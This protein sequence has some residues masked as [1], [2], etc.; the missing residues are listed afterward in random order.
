MKIDFS[1]PPLALRAVL[2][3]DQ[4]L[5]LAMRRLHRPWCTRLMKGLT[6]FGD[7]T[8]WLILGLVLAAV[9]T[10][11]TTRLAVLL[12]AG[13]GLAAGLAQLLKRVLRRRRPDAGIAGFRALVMNPDAFSF[14]SGHTAAAVA[15]AVSVVGQGEPLALLMTALATG[16]GFS[17]VYL[18]AHYPLDVAAGATIG[19]GSGAVVQLAVPGLFF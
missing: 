18:G 6:H 10:E 4:A 7:G 19:L 13:A 15:V 9:G 11:H 17:R 2:G 5:L 3:W 8:S 14:P 1:L 12:G 16:I